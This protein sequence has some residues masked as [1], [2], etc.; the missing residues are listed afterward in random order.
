MPTNVERSSGNVFSDLGF[1]PEESQNLKMRADL[2]I[3]LGKLI[4][5]RRLT[6]TAAAKLLGVTQPRISDLMR[7]KI[8]RFSVDTLIAMLGH[9]GASISFSI[10][11][12]RLVAGRVSRG[13]LPAPSSSK[14]PACEFPRTRLKHSE[15]RLPDP[16]VPA[17]LPNCLRDTHLKPPDLFVD[18]PPIDGRPL[19]G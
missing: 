19:Q 11:T 7:G 8:D 18:P 12:S 16:A 14:N 5:A 6:Q 4:E 2:M 10:T 3:E 17:E 13:P 9:A 15:G 1:C